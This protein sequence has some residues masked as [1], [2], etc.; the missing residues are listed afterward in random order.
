MYT[1]II[2]LGLTISLTLIMATPSVGLATES[3][4]GI[5]K[6]PIGQGL[7]YDH[8]MVEK[9]PAKRKKESPVLPYIILSWRPLL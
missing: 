9:A 3:Q 8:K 6:S 7:Q 1:R 2:I 4:K 5:N